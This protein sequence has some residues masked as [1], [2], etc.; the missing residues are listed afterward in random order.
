[1]PRTRLNLEH[2][3]RL[4]SRGKWFLIGAFMASSL[5]AQQACAGENKTGPKKER[6]P[7][8]ALAFTPD[9]KQVLSGD[10]KGK[11]QVW[12]VA[13]KKEV[14][15]FFTYG[16]EARYI[17]VAFPPDG[18]LAVTGCFNLYQFP[19]SFLDIEKRAFLRVCG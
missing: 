5:F 15:H 13:S 4:R 9:G 8:T 10:H 17:R 14:R 2:C 12:D 3:P 1:M 7:I 16:Q 19:L 11:V 6:R 18:K